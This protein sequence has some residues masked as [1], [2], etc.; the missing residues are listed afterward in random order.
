MA[1][2][3]VIFVVVGWVRIS[4]TEE[5]RAGGPVCGGARVIHSAVYD[6]CKPYFGVNVERG[7]LVR[8]SRAERTDRWQRKFLPKQNQTTPAAGV[9]SFAVLPVRPG[10][11]ILVR[12]CSICVGLFVCCVVFFRADSSSSTAATASLEKLVRDNDTIDRWISGRP[13]STVW[14]GRWRHTH[15]HTKFQEKKQQPKSR[16][17]SFRR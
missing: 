16:A 17:E 2:T 8:S 6:A 9:A 1:I 3:D 14:N 4:E 5:T 12:L 10:R 15:T 13:R 11:H 7:A